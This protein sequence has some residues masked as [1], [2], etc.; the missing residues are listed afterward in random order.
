MLARLFDNVELYHGILTCINGCH[1]I[2]TCIRGHRDI[3]WFQEYICQMNAMLGV[4][5]LH[6][7]ICDFNKLLLEGHFQLTMEMLLTLLA[8]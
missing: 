3:S 2:L 8:I 4:G 6:K 1:C 7:N 5:Y